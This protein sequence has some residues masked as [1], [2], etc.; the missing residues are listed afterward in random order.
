M[1]CGI[2]FYFVVWWFSGECWLLMCLDACACTVL[3]ESTSSRQKKEL[4]VLVPNE[5]HNILYS[6]EAK[7]ITIRLP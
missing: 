3:Q 2:G 7:V 1:L 4:S 6:A 5:A